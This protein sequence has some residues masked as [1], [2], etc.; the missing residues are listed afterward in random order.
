MNQ[1]ADQLFILAGTYTVRGS[2]GVYPLVLDLK[3]GRLSLAGEAAEVENPTYLAIDAKRNLLFAASETNRYLEHSGGSLAVFRMKSVKAEQSG[4]P[5]GQSGQN[6][7]C[8]PLIEGISL[9]KIDQQPVG[10]KS[11]C[12]MVVDSARRLIAV[13]NYSSGSATIVAYDESGKIIQTDDLK[14][15]IIQHKGHGTDPDKIGRAHV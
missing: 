10:G 12:H 7:L 5:A 4:M 8:E 11:P 9:E 15:Q 13:A 6:E 3:N 1:S 2:K 14:Q